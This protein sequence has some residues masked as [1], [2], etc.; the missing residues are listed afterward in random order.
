MRMKRQINP[1]NGGIWPCLDFSPPPLAQ[2]L[3]KADPAPVAISDAGLNRHRALLKQLGEQGDEALAAHLAHGPLRRLSEIVCDH[4]PYLTRLIEREAAFL[5][6][7]ADAPP[8]ATFDA[9]VAEVEALGV[10][11]SADEMGRALRVA[12]RRMALIAA[13][14]DLGRLWP[15]AVVVRNLSTFADAAIARA[16]AHSLG[17]LFRK[18]NLAGGDDIDAAIA[19]SGYSVLA[20]GKLG[21]RE[22]N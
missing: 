1:E 5:A 3:A 19:A 18:G 7:H 6:A 14:A 9:L 17:A 4:S 12:K 10:G 21:G 8:Q 20:L 15:L 13:L 22:L 2:P 16:V 11:L